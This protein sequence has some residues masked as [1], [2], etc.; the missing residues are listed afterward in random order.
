MDRTTQLRDLALRLSRCVAAGD[1]AGLRVVD[2]E[3]EALLS[4]G[5]WSAG[6]RATAASLWRVHDHALQ[7]CRD[8]VAKVSGQLRDLCEH[9]DGWLAYAL[10][11]SGWRG[12]SA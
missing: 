11:S 1:W 7:R 8:E 10:E 9:R 5:P 2:V 12:E 3:I 6:E 4:H